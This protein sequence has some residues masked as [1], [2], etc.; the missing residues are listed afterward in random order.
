MVTAAGGVDSS[1]NIDDILATIAQDVVEACPVQG[2][3]I[4]RNTSKGDPT[5]THAPLSLF[6][7]PY[8]L[9]IYRDVLSVQIPMGDL[10]SGIVADP[11]KN[12]HGL[13]AN[14]ATKD[15]FMA[16]LIGVSKEF[17]D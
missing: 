7:T 11:S 8:P 14:F 17:N 1:A 10:I 9:D 2:L 6:P 5:Y 16:R 13:L 15:A 3:M 4:K 12:I